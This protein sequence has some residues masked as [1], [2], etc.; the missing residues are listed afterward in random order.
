LTVLIDDP[1]YESRKARM[2]IVPAHRNNVY[3][4]AVD[5]RSRGVAEQ[6][7]T[8]SADPRFLDWWPSEVADAG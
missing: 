1:N 7:L 2:Q 6:H 3:Y 8:L 5:R 4:G